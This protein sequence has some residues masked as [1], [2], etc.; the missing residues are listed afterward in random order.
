MPEHPSPSPTSPSPPGVHVDKQTSLLLAPP[1]WGPGA[2]DSDAERGPPR[3]RYRE[4]YLEEDVQTL[5]SDW[6]DDAED[7]DDESVAP[8][9]SDSSNGRSADPIAATTP[10]LTR[11]SPKPNGKKLW[12]RKLHWRPPG[13]AKTPKRKSA[14]TNGESPP[15]TPT[16]NSPSNRAVRR[17]P[18]SG[19]S[20]TTF[21]SNAST[22]FTTK[23]SS[24]QRHSNRTN[25]K[26]AACTPA[27]A[28]SVSSMAASS[29]LR[30][31]TPPLARLR[32]RRRTA[33]ERLLEKRDDADE[34][35]HSLPPRS[36][37]PSSIRKEAFQAS[38]ILE[39]S[40]ITEDDNSLVEGDSPANDVGGESDERS[41]V[42]FGNVKINV[43][44]NYTTP[45][46]SADANTSGPLNK[47]G[48]SPTSV[49][50][51]SEV[52]TSKPYDEHSHCS[53][54]TTL[55]DGLKR[56]KA[57]AEER[58]GNTEQSSVW[59]GI[60][61]DDGSAADE[62]TVATID[63][64]KPG[65]I[66]VD[67]CTR[68]LTSEERRNLSAMH[69][70]GYT[71]LRNN[72]LPQ[73]LGVFA[74]ILRGQ[75]ERHG[76]RSLQAA[77]AIHNLGVVCMRDRRYMETVRLCD[78]A[79]RIR[80]EKLG[81]NSTEVAMSLSQ[82]GV[83]LMELREYP[84]ALASFREALRIRRRASYDGDSGVDSEQ[85]LIVRLLNNIGCAHFEMNQLTESRSAF[86]EA[87]VLQRELMKARKSAAGAESVNDSFNVNPKDAFHAPLSIALALTNLGSIH[88]RLQEFEAS[89]LYF[90]EAVLVSIVV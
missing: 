51:L 43:T 28:S 31:N 23:S 17:I 47:V 84:V 33:L 9:A 62:D 75:K 61:V 72:E 19:A 14:A 16:K 25:A 83:A 74:E 35:N 54:M 45:T 29:S 11:K 78:G 20:V 21:R 15:S 88:L 53:N 70:L 12:R 4:E 57:V 30:P 36:S 38:S 68:H 85:Q 73:A 39:T 69:Q 22:I 41:H 44:T 76:K 90:E 5:L 80:V 58:K 52:G 48:T 89:L 63:K 2:A 65:P 50:G 60:K 81:R 87:L 8:A 7:S 59:D 6:V 1:S 56:L 32:R 37:L 13:M 18:S 27:Q 86:N 10:P 67:S 46:K 71:H 34:R 26:K 66:D 42:T 64:R 82:Q 40:A 49:M 55:A 79:A 77:T 24:T 3:C